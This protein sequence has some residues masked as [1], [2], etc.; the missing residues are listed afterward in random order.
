M[1]Q[2]QKVKELMLECCQGTHDPDATDI[3]YGYGID[4]ILTAR[5]YGVI[6]RSCCTQ[7]ELHHAHVTLRDGCIG[8]LTISFGESNTRKVYLT[9]VFDDYDDKLHRAETE[10]K[11]RI[12]RWAAE[13]Q[14]EE[15][16]RTARRWDPAHQLDEPY[17]REWLRRED[18]YQAWKRGEAKVNAETA[19]EFETIAQTEQRLIDA[20]GY[21]KVLLWARR[22][23]LEPTR[24]ELVERHERAR[25][26]EESS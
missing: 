8:E 21:L 17:L 14:R 24:D 19:E 18:Q 11:E 1:R 12:A 5:L 9:D 4:D 22:S 23:G 15:K 6:E 16:E 20:T 13:R 26:W 25:K 3:G 2:T 7:G 10:E